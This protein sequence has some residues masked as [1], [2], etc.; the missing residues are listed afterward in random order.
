MLL[1]E[2][3]PPG[4]MSDQECSEKG[5][6][7]QF[8]RAGHSPPSCNLTSGHRSP[9]RRSSHGFHSHESQKER[10]DPAGGPIQTHSSPGLQL[11][12]MPEPGAHTR[13][14]QRQLLCSGD[15]VND[16]LSLVAELREE[17]ER[18]RSIRECESEIDWWSSTL[19]SLRQRQ[20]EAAPQEAEDPRP[21]YHRAER[22]DLRDGGETGHCSRWQANPLLALL[23][24]P[25][26]LKQQ[27]R[28]SGM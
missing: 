7:R 8:A 18:L 17:M 14:Q 20:Q 21:S 13:G 15:Q 11:Q 16:L 24:S 5:A 25:V 1:K 27:I 23:T 2:E 3:Q 26:A 19:P 22:G 10:G 28:D 6:A 4:S 12:G 9:R